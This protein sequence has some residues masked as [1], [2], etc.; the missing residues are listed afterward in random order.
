MSYVAPGV[1]I[2]GNALVWGCAHIRGNSILEGDVTFSSGHIRDLH[3]WR[4]VP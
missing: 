1:K 2:S 3:W 4:D